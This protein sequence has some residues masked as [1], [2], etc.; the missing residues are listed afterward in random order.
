M[1]KVVIVSLMLLAFI[2]GW[3]ASSYTCGNCIKI[4]LFHAFTG[5]EK[6]ISCDLLFMGF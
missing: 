4:A 5:T 6:P 2:L 3:F 1:R